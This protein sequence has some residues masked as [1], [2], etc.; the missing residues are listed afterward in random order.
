MH[1]VTGASLVNPLDGGLMGNP[2]LVD[3]T[4]G[5][6]TPTKVLVELSGD[7]SHDLFEAGQLVLQVLQSVMENVY[8]GVLLPNQFTKVATLT[9]S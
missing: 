3:L 6:C 8:F 5:G 4:D 2:S 9:K 1:P 7:A